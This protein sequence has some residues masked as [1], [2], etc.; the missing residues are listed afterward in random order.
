MQIYTGTAAGENLEMIKKKG[1]G[2]MISPSP[3]F[4]PRKE[5]SD[6]PCA[7]DNGAFQAHKRG[8]PFMRGLFMDT[9][10][11]CYCVGLSL[12][13]IVCPDI[14]A[15]G[16]RSLDFSLDWAMGELRTVPRLALAVQDG[17]DTLQVKPFLEYFTHIFIGGSVSWKWA[18][19]HEWMYFAHTNK[20][21][22]HVGQCGTIQRGQRAL[23]LGADSIDSTS[24]VRNKTWDYVDEIYNG[25]Q[26]RLFK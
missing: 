18:T 8:F 13:F 17:M 12:D 4:L 5:W 16:K 6:I 14:V 22:V 2:I 3:S 10:E 9:I 1:L 21:K 15:G 24:F 26:G 20:K 23:E 11:K 19:A 25:K 7:L